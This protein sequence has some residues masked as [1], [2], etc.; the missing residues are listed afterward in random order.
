MKEIFEAIQRG[1]ARIADAI[2]YD[3]TGYAENKNASG[4]VQLKLDIRSD[5]IIEEELS[6]ESSSSMM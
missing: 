6:R 5:Y 3:D 2:K 1:A 4:D